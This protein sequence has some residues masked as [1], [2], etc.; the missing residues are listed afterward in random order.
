MPTLP[1]PG[2]SSPPVNAAGS[3]QGT[4]KS[5]SELRD[6]PGQRPGPRA[7][8]SPPGPVL[9]GAGA[10][11]QRLGGQSGRLGGDGDGQAVR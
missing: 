1:S 11:G 8:L 7:G 2:L 9:Q 4:Q 6:L 5:D 3:S 10:R